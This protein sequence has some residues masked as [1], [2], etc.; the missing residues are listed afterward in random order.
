MRELYKSYM[1]LIPTG[2]AWTEQVKISLLAAP[3]I[4]AAIAG[5]MVLTAIQLWR[6]RLRSVAG[7]LGFSALNLLAAM[8]AVSLVSLE[9]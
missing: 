2:G 7:Q 8:A 5:V 4:V 9:R 6:Q 1:L 3:W